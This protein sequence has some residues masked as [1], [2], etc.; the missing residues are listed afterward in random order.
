MIAFNRISSDVLRRHKSCNPA[1]TRSPRLR[2]QRETGGF[3]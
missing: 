2:V 1:S 3:V